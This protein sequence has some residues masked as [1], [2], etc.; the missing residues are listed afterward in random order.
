MEPKESNRFVACRYSDEA[1]GRS[2]LATVDEL[3]DANVMISGMGGTFV[4]QGTPKVKQ[5]ISFV[6]AVVP[7]LHMRIDEELTD[8]DRVILR[9]TASGT[10]RGEWTKGI[11]AT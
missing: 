1:W 9:W 5:L 6:R 11:P 10:Q 4:R 2:N 7:D 8:G 3:C